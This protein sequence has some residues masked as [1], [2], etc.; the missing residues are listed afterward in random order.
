MKNVGATIG[1]RSN[2]DTVV[3]VS[4]LATGGFAAARAWTAG[5][6]TPPFRIAAG[7]T[8]TGALLL[9]VAPSQ[10]KLAMG[11]ALTIALTSAIMSQD[12]LKVGALRLS[13]DGANLT[14]DQFRAKLNPSKKPTGNRKA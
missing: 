5:D 4:M 12:V 7:V 10:P 11:F 14:G 13:A 2:A 3:V 8:I 9:T 1:A 6:R